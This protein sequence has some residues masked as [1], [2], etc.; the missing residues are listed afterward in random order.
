[1]KKI[2]IFTLLTALFIVKPVNASWLFFQP[3]A[4]NLTVTLPESKMNVIGLHTIESDGY[5]FGVNSTP[6]VYNY[7]IPYEQSYDKTYFKLGYIPLCDVN[8]TNAYVT[9]FCGDDYI[10]SWNLTA[11]CPAANYQYTWVEFDLSNS[12]QFQTL[13]ASSVL[14]C[15]FYVNDTSVDNRTDIWVRMENV[16]TKVEI[17][18]KT[19]E[20]FPELE[21]IQEAINNFITLI[22]TVIVLATGLIS[23]FLP[24]W[25][26]VAW[27]LF[28]VFMFQRL[29]AKAKE[30]SKKRGK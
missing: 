16:G 2:I 8:Q 4:L 18:E 1:M 6:I 29:R 14:N 10:Y 11:N 13:T 19:R 9:L 21:A 23:G 5:G 24:I 26:T 3:P 27:I 15:R 12:T 17:E 25:L 20:I 28:G 22:N 7:Q 30:L